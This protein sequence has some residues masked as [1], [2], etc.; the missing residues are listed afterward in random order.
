MALRPFASAGPIA[1]P[2]WLTAVEA[3]KLSLEDVV[4]RMS[5]NPARIFDLPPQPDTWIEVDPDQTW[6]V[7]AVRA[8]SRCGWTPFEGWQ[9]RGRVTSVTLRGQ[10]AYDG[11]T[12]TA[13]PGSG[14]NVRAAP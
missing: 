1:L 12:V 11:E 4:S 14:R 7:R 8:Q 13:T 5:A 10:L 3:G 6:T 2:L 9:L